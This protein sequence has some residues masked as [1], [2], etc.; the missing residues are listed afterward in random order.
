[1]APLQKANLLAG[2]ALLGEDVRYHAV[3]A[4]V[5]KLNLAMKASLPP[6]EGQ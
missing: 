4:A 3:G 2:S 1:M 6:P 5:L